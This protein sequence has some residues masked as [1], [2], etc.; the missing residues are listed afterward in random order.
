MSITADAGQI[1]HTKICNCLTLATLLQTINDIFK[2]VIVYCKISI[3]GFLIKLFLNDIISYKSD[4]DLHFNWFVC[5]YLSQLR[6]DNF[7]ISPSRGS[8]VHIW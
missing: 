6:V 5:Q 8:K 3:L 2:P 4:H 1:Q 7:Q